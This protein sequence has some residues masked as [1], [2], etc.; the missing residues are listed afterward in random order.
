MA[1]EV[2]SE[3][4]PDYITSTPSD[5]DEPPASPPAPR[6]GLALLSL[7][8]AIAALALSG[9]HYWND[10]N[11]VTEPADADPW[12]GTVAELE[13]LRESQDGSR[14]ATQRLEARIEELESTSTDLRRGIDSAARGGDELDAVRRETRAELANLRE[15]TSG[16]EQRTQ[17]AEQSLINISDNAA[18]SERIV[19]LTEAEYLLRLANERLSLSRDPKSAWRALQLAR[20]QLSAVDDPLYNG[21]LQSIAAEMESL[22]TVEQPDISS[23]SGRLIAAADAVDTWPVAGER[24]SRLETV[25]GEVEGDGLWAKSQSLMRRLVVIERSSDPGTLQLTPA[26]IQSVRA[27]AQ[28]ELRLLRSALIERD[29]ALRDQNAERAAQMIRENFDT[30]SAAVAQALGAVAAAADARLTAELPE[31]GDALRQLRA[32]RRDRNATP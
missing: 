17:R 18:G 3:E 16:L 30:S 28:L 12:A 29:V 32:L 24:Q 9:W 27:D 26:Q 31:I 19:N 20:D 13:A 11:A 2:S 6:S 10:R 15:R 8:L 22:A 4:R 5:K 1:E 21:V 7:L 14:Q 23:L 25:Q